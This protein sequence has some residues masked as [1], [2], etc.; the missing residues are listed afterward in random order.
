M[1][2][3]YYAAI[4]LFAL[5]LYYADKRKA[6]KKAWRI[7]EKTLILVSF[8]GGGIG[9]F[10][11]MFLFHHKTRKMK[12]RVLV[13]VAIFLHI[14]LVGA[15]VLPHFKWDNH[16]KI[17]EVLG[18]VEKETGEVLDTDTHFFCHRGYAGK[19]PE[20]SRIAEKMALKEGVYGTNYDIW[21]AQKRPR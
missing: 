21:R 3:I 8:L 19:Y 2:W 17:K 15:V 4:N 10:V 5:A 16:A 12:F 14:L 6:Q 7:P 11:A 20:N 9:S 18:A 13:P 1:I